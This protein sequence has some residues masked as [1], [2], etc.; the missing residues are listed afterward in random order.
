[1]AY[2]LQEHGLEAAKRRGEERSLRPKRGSRRPRGLL[3]IS[4]SVLYTTTEY[5]TTLCRDNSPAGL[6]GL[7]HERV[8]VRATGH[9]HWNAPMI[10]NTECEVKVSPSTPSVHTTRNT[11]GHL[12][13]K[14]S[15]IHLAGEP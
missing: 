7:N 1:M 13:V 11:S 12:A 6:A 14:F 5:T 10:S 3:L 8:V 9:D 2:G 4:N 15:P